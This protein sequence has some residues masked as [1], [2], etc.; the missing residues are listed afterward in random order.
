MPGLFRAFVVDRAA[1][2]PELADHRRPVP[3]PV[4]LERLPLRPDADHARATIVP[5]TLGIY[6]YLGAHIADWS[7]VMATAMLA[8]IPAI[9][10]LVL[11]QKYIAAGANSGAVK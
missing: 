6:T 11:A 1:D 9:V 4:R 5:V 7:A 8:S 10:L 3:L 2:Q